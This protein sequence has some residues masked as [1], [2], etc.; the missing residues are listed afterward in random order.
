MPR[1]VANRRLSRDDWTAEALLVLG[2]G[3]L[4]SVAIEP[5]ATRLGTT[6]GSGYWHFRSRADLVTAT[7]QRWEREHTE[8]VIARADTGVDPVDRLRELLRVVLGRSG[9]FSVE[10]ALLASSDDPLV[11]PT[12]RRVTQRRLDYLTG[13]F[14]SLDF[15][16]VSAGRR[17][18]LAYTTYLGHAQL[19]RT[20]PDAV[21]PGGPERQAYLDS[22]L[23]TL[24][25]R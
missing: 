16:P 7:L 22:V 4:A 23:A 3:G 5:I 13:L 14:T 20:V 10:L 15:D 12:V 17:A 8:A 18:L 19:A 9:A 24:L 11:A 1:E 6:K 2:A 21:A 25:G